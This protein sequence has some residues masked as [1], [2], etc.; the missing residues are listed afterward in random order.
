M[1]AQAKTDFAK[2]LIPLA[3][4]LLVIIPLIAGVSR[5]TQLANG[6]SGAVVI[7]PANARFFASP[8]PVILHIVSAGLYAVLGAFQF[9]SRPFRRRGTGRSSGRSWHQIAGWLLIPCGLMVA[10]SGL[11]MTLFYPWPHGDGVVLY[12]LRLLFGSAMTLAIVLGITAIQRRDFI[13]HGNWMLR[14]YAIG[15]G[16]GTQTLTLMIGELVLGPP[17]ELSRA[18]LMGLAWLI[19]LAV[20]E[21]VIGRQRSFRRPHPHPA[22]AVT[23]S[24]Q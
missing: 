18:L 13:Q 9:I 1:K 12:G 24:Q 15:L 10:L 3:L 23:A 21:W 17:N 7:T 16:A 5:L 20:A 8:L 6:A 11:W 14:G 22:S 4:N 2:L 19:N